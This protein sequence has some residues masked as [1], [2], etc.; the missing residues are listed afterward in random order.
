MT[1]DES[2]QRVPNRLLNEREQIA[3][4]GSLAG[5]SR[6]TVLLSCIGMLLLL[7][8]VTAFA[9]RMYHKNIHVLADQWFAKGEAAFHAGDPAEAAK[10]YRNALVYSADNTTFQFHLAQALTAAHKDDEA[11]SYLLNLLADSP[12]SGEINLELARISAR[13]TTKASVQDTLRYYNGAIYGVWDQDPLPKR[14]DAR[15]E[16]CE[17]LL[18]HE[19]TVQAQP[20]AIALA[21]DVPP[22]DLTRE[23]EA[24][25]ML[26]RAGL[27]DRALA[28]Y[29][30]I[31]ASHK[32]DA[33]AL[34]GA[35]AA[36]FQ[37]SQYARA[38]QYLDEVPHAK[39]TPQAGAT[40]TLAREVEALS[41]YLRGLSAR[42]RARRTAAS[43]ARARALAQEC[44]QQQSASANA[45]LQKLQA[46]ITTNSREWTELNFVRHPDQIDP[47]MTWV[48]DVE[49]AAA[50]ACGQSKNLA[51]R[52]LLLIAKS[53]TSPEA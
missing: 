47:A 36:A 49:A 44:S 53:R 9:S 7:T 10:D 23:K 30:A 11:R 27:W 52:A 22:G 12:G 1:D 46:T 39:R 34:A 13:R 3:L 26:T 51:D 38:V 29:R 19:T 14:W 31:L 42:E 4:A 37:L 43:L 16:L 5:Y 2:A 20:E 15:R 25:A 35:G 21:Q 32:R 41:P 28:E 6:E 18:A 40:L 24:A 8:G 33:D 45:A 50:Q 17:Y 48:F